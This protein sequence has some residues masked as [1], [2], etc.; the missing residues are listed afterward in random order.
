MRKKV[1]SKNM[2]VYVLVVT[3]AL[4]LLYIGNRL[5]SRETIIDYSHDEFQA[6]R[7]K[8]TAVLD[9]QTEE[10]EWWSGTSVLFEAEILSGSYAGRTVRVIQ[11]IGSHHGNLDSEVR[12]GDRVLL[13]VA[14]EGWFFAGHVKINAVLI[15][16]IVFALL[17]ILFGR[18]KGVNAILSLGFKCAAIFAVFIPAILSGRNI[19]ISAIIVCVYSIVVTLFI[20]Y[21]VNRKSL[22][23]IAGCFGGVIAAGLLTLL[24]SSITRLTGVLDTESLFLLDLPTGHPIDLKAII[25]AGII[26]G[27]VGAIM[28]V[29]VSISSALFELMAQAPELAFKELFKSGINIGKDIMASMTNTL[30]LAYIGSSLSVLLIIIVYSASLTEL[31]NREMII[32]ELLQAIIGSMGILF[33]LPLTALVCAGLFSPA[34][35]NGD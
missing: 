35:N 1:F 18:M 33:A 9:V 8:V 13:W 17:L 16:G 27:A 3:L 10:T 12:V 11:D 5:A 7:A 2:I 14:E 30:V 34:R 31:L 24:M 29:A 32:V 19:Y 28:D 22:A 26:I 4:L 20:L 21:G 6:T 23:A 25:F 15:L